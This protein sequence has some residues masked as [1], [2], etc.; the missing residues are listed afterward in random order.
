[1][2]NERRS[3]TVSPMSTLPNTPDFCDYPSLF[4]SGPTTALVTAVAQ[5]KR[6]VGYHR[7]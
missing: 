1:L 7:R 6:I 4:A 3:K 2:G 5:R